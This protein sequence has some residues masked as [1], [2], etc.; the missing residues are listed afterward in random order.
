[1][2]NPVADDGEVRPLVG[3]LETGRRQS[4]GQSQA[5]ERNYQQG[6]QSIC[7]G[8]IGIRSPA[9]ISRQG[10]LAW[11]GSGKQGHQVWMCLDQAHD[12]RQVSSGARR[13]VWSGQ[14]RP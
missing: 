8:L 3:R 7:S 11:N 10:A 4:V 13:V 1:M 12:V 9:Q 14:R 2:L 6:Q 5:R